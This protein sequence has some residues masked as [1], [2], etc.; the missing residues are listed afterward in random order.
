[1]PFGFYFNY[2]I[3]NFWEEGFVTDLIFVIRMPKELFN[4]DIIRNS[5]EKRF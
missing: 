5:S 1:L 3:D 2:I 4:K